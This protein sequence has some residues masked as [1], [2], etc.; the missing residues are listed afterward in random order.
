MSILLVG[1]IIERFIVTGFGEHGK[2]T[3]CEKFGLPFSSS[4]WFACN[5]FIFDALKDK[6]GYKTP[7]EC[8]EDRKSKRVEWYNLIRDYNKGN[9]IRLAESLFSK[10]PVY[11][12]IRAID[13]FNAIKTSHLNGG[14]LLSIWVDASER[15]PPESEGSMTVT[16]EDCDIIV[17][18]NTTK[19]E[20]LAKVQRLSLLLGAVKGNA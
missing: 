14:K 13:E 2:D 5:E 1:N 4:S 9:E 8:F 10:F 6:Y 3:F 11:C 20:F 17:T 19:A 12:G 7:M 16:K 15:L 18:N